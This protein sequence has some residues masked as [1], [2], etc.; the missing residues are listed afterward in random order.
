[1]A[2]MASGAKPVVITESG[3]H[4]ALNDHNDQPAVSEA[5]AAKYIPRLFLE[6]FT[7]DIARTYLYEFLDEKA[8]PEL[9]DN[10]LHWGLV[11][12]DG[13][14]KPA[15]T[16][17]KNLITLLGDST[18]PAQT[19]S[20]SWSLSINDSSVHH[21]LLQ[22]SN[23]EFDL[24]LWQE[25]PSYDTKAQQDISVA[26]E[27]ATVILAQPA[28]RIT[29]YEPSIQAAALKTVTNTTQ[30]QLAIP[31]SPIVLKILP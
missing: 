10:Q 18:E 4:N 2:K 7:R 5:A 1:M 24:I 12:A 21:L 26:P 27:S 16:A 23:G 11:R 17:L 13:S 31:D 20:L 25:V 3:Y 28:K 30:M 29:A 9:K 22:Q 8:D 14:E 15:F 6:N 19:R